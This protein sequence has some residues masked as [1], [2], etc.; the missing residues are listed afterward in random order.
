MPGFVSHTS[1]SP[2]RSRGKA[3]ALHDTEATE[4]P[5]VRNASQKAC[6]SFASVMQN[7]TPIE[8]CPLRAANSMISSARVARPY[9]SHAATCE[10]TASIRSSRTYDRQ[11]CSKALPHVEHSLAK[12]AVRPDAHSRFLHWSQLSTAAPFPHAP[13]S[14]PTQAASSRQRASRVRSHPAPSCGRPARMLLQAK[15]TA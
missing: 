5:F 13:S 2:K 7:A 9:P 10:V 8:R 14:C 3:P 11:D 1:G 6:A 4:K 15:Q 12:P